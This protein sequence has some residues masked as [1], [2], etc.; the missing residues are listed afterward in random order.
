MLLPLAIVAALLT[1]GELLAM[2][3]Q[4]GHDPLSWIVYGGT[5]VTVVAAAVPGLWPA[6]VAGDFGARHRL[7]G[8]W[9]GD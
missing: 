6:A 2:F 4:R 7:G 8:D 1:A 9:I 5:L 3:R